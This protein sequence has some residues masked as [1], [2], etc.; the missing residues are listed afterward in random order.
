MNSL[1][2]FVCSKLLIARLA[3]FRCIRSHKS[4]RDSA[5]DCATCKA[6][7]AAKQIS[8]CHS[9]KLPQLYTIRVVSS[10]TL[11]QYITRMYQ[12][13]T[14]AELDFLTINLL[15]LTSYQVQRTYFGTTV[16]SPSLHLSGCVCVCM[17]RSL[18]HKH[19]DII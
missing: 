15:Q 1:Y 19:Y 3:L 8:C 18:S 2:C 6:A 11:M 17:L 9:A 5:V 12:V 16:S 4:I 13:Q 10:H 7:S 14:S